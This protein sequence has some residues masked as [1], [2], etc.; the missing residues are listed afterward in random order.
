MPLP[1][2]DEMDNFIAKACK[3][4]I[5]ML[6][7]NIRDM[8]IFWSYGYY[9]DQPDGQLNYECMPSASHGEN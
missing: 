9:D 8:Q 7:C 5:L 2:I 6:Y 3:S 1:V 4:T